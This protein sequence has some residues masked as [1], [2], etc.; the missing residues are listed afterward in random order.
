MAG[1]PG[2][3]PP[4]TPCPEGPRENREPSLV[5]KGIPVPLDLPVLAG[6][7]STIIFFFGTFPMLH[8]AVRTKDLRSYSKSML[9]ANSVANVIHAL[10]IFSLP[11]GPI[12]ALHSFY[13]V[14]TALMLYWAIRY[15]DRPARNEGANVAPSPHVAPA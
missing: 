5:T 14:T 6:T 2:G 7:L 11:P 12:W 3:I 4:L 10:Y 15:D 13:M 9:G 8:K 1:G